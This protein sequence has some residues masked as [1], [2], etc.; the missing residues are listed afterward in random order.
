MAIGCS[1]QLLQ[2]SSQKAHLME[3]AV[4]E[5]RRGGKDMELKVTAFPRIKHGATMKEPRAQ[6][7]GQETE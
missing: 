2:G 5:V 6:W 1:Q 4:D 7:Q 3:K